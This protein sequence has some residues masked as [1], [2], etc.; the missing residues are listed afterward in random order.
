VESSRD[1]AQW[2][3]VAATASL[4]DATLAL[5]RDPRHGRGALR[6]APR[7]ARFLRVGRDVPAR[8]GTLERIP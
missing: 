6:F 3:D 2:D 1:G 8:E 5:Y 7:E 4:A